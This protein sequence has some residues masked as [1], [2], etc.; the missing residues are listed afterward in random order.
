MFCYGLDYGMA[1]LMRHIAIRAFFT[2]MVGTVTPELWEYFG[3]SYTF[4]R[5]VE[6]VV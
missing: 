4:G 5:D 6:L 3:G 2:L 1:V